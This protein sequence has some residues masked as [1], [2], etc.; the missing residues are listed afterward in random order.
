MFSILQDTQKLE[1]G[2]LTGFRC[3]PD[4]SENCPMFL[5]S[6]SC[7]R[8]DYYFSS[9]L[10]TGHGLL[11]N[12][13][14]WCLHLVYFLVLVTRKTLFIFRWKTSFLFICCAAFLT[15]ENECPKLGTSLDGCSWLGNSFGFHFSHYLF[16]HC[17]QLCLDV[18]TT[19]NHRPIL[20]SYN[21]KNPPLAVY[22][23]MICIYWLLNMIDIPLK[24]EEACR[25]S[26]PVHLSQWLNQVTV[27]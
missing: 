2:L 12:A 20:R 8:G 26:K 23:P 15:L 16:V 18:Q 13:L 10:N 4:C 24:K 27:K 17:W 19:A 14:T 25:V 11:S 3:A 5:S 7:F 21:S 22:S 1:V 6:I 9:C